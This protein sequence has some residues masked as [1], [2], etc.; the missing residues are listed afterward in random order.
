MAF[1]ILDTRHFSGIY[2][3]KFKLFYSIKLFAMILVI[4]KK[5]LL[6]VHPYPYGLQGDPTSPF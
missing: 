5:V 6:F 2:N 3:K 4:A 1:N